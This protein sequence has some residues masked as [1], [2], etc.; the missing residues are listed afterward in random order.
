MIAGKWKT[1]ILYNLS[2]GR[3]RLNELMRL[4]PTI[5]QRT[6]TTQ[7]R[8]LEQDGLVARQIF[9]EVPPRVEYSLTTLGKTLGPILLS[10]K[11]WAE[12]NVPE[13]IGPGPLPTQLAAVTSE[14][15]NDG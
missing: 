10:L 7:L 3:F 2:T 9:A 11:Q 8:E 12:V 6:L 4:L 13:R 1:V 5:T 15:D 14:C